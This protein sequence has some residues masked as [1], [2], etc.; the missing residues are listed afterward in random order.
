MNTTVA[1]KWVKALRSGKFKQGHNFLKTSRKNKVRHCCLGVLCEL[2]DQEQKR[3]HKKR[4][5]QT[6]A[7]IYHYVD[8]EL[9]YRIDNMVDVLPKAVQKWAGIK[10][11]SGN[12]SFINRGLFAYETL[13]DMND[14][15]CTFNRIAKVIEK[16][17][18]G[19]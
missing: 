18:E 5:K 15:G 6:A 3:K 16:H 4:L 7:R 17:A 9:C 2:Y 13:V 1:K 12:V 8:D 10:D 11:K 19:I 14:G